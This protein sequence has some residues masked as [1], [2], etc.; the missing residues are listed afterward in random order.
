MTPTLEIIPGS[1]V[2]S[3]EFSVRPEI[4]LAFPALGTLFWVSVM[5]AMPYPLGPGQFGC[6]RLASCMPYSFL[7]LP[8]F[9]GVLVAPHERGSQEK[10]TG[11]STKK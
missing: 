11:L 7:L 10:E 1:M 3:S 8:Y 5:V 2:T 4:L 6:R 9:S